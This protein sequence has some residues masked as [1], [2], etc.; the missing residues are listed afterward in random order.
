MATPKSAVRVSAQ[1]ARSTGRTGSDDRAGGASG[2]LSRRL[3]RFASKVLKKA[4]T[5]LL[6]L[7]VFDSSARMPLRSRR[8][9]AQP[10]SKVLVAKRG[11]MLIL[12]RP[13]LTTTPS[14]EGAQPDFAAMFEGSKRE[15][16]VEAMQELFPEGA[17]VLRSSSRRA[18][19]V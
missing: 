2:S 6:P 17:R 7:K 5:P 8:I 10:L 14:N 15:S 1:G 11:E 4:A 9:A 19:R 16:H 3:R 12:H 13:G 18:T